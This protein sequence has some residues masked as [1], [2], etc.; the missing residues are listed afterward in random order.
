VYVS[1]SSI[2][3]IYMVCGIYLTDAVLHMP[4]SVSCDFRCRCIF[5]AWRLPQIVDTI[6]VLSVYLYAIRSKSMQMLWC[7]L[8]SNGYATSPTFCAHDSTPRN[9]KQSSMR[10][11]YRMWLHTYKHPLVSNLISFHSTGHSLHGR[12]DNFCST[13]QPHKTAS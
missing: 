13:S 4:P 10:M 3:M 1:L 5:G 11:H 7:I 9:P 2:Y 8:V 6:L 12:K